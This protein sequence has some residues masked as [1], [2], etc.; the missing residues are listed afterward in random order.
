MPT[1]QSVSSLDPL[2]ALVR[3]AGLPALTVL[4]LTT[5]AGDGNQ[6]C[7][8][9]ETDDDD[10]HVDIKDLGN[11]IITFYEEPGC[12]LDNGEYDAFDEGT[13]IDSPLML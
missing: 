1:P 4:S 10:D 8:P 11:C 12:P 13:L 2:L 7:T 9:I 5:I 6:G 3:V